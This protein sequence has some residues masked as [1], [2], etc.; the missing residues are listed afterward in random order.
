MKLIFFILA[1]LTYNISTEAQ[2]TSTN[3]AKPKSQ[4]PDPF[5][6]VE[7]MPEFPGGTGKMMKYI[8]ENTRYPQSAKDSAYS[9]TSYI[10]FIVDTAGYIKEATVLKGMRHCPECDQEALRVVKAMP[11][12][13]PGR[14]NGNPVNVYYNLPIRFRLQ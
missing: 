13:K 6:V 2:I 5:R 8:S 3:T 11:R 1:S 12:W 7:E 10:R 4:L 9:G 14:Q